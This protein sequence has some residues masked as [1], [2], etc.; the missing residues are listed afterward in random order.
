[1]DRIGIR[2]KEIA[3]ID[4]ILMHLLDSNFIK[5]VKR[6]DIYSHRK[7]KQDVGVVSLVIHTR[8]DIRGFH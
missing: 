4:L 3:C 6:L 5:A 8:L 1:M 2:G 7:L